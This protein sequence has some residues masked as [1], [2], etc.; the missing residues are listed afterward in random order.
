M[1]QW[2]EEHFGGGGVWV[3]TILDPD[4]LL[5]DSFGSRFDFD[6]KPVLLILD[7]VV[8]GKSDPVQDSGSLKGLKFNFKTTI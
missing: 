4:P 2:K 3:T 1:D 8:M 5:N 6:L 7:L